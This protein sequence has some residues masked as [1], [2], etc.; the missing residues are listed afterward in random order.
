MGRGSLGGILYGRSE[1]PIGFPRRGEG[2]LK[3][4]GGGEG[5]DSGMEDDHA[6]ICESLG[7]EWRIVANFGVQ[8]GV[9]PSSWEWGQRPGDGF[10]Y[11][12][13]GPEWVLA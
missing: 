1:V 9:K 3:H 10:S 5:G 11:N 8:W 12:T 6:D 13:L 2:T 4:S 7:C